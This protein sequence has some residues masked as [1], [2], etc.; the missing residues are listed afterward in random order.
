MFFGS[1]KPYLTL[2]F[3]CEHQGRAHER[4]REQKYLKMHDVYQNICFLGLENQIWH[5]FLCASN[6]SA[7]TNARA[8]KNTLKCMRYIELYVFGVEKAISDIIFFVRAP[9]P[10]TR[11]RART[12]ILK[13]AWCISKYMFFG[14]RKPNLTSFFM[15]EQRERVHERARAQKYF[16]MHDVHQYICILGLESQIWHCLLCAINASAHKNT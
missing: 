15:C 5:H 2:F 9:R 7:F 14:S 11:T 1:K 6:V 3:S 16:K 12:K 13:N 8:H 10:R 4:A